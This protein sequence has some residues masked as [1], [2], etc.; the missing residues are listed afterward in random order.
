M[1]FGLLLLF[2]FDKDF[3]RTLQNQLDLIK[4]FDKVVDTIWVTE[5]HYSPI[6]LNSNPLMILNHLI[7][8]TDKDLGIATLL[9]SL[10]DPVYISEAISLLSNLSKRKIYIGA[11]KG[12]RSEVKNSHLNLKEE[13]ARERLLHTFDLVT[14]LAKNQTITL[15]DK[16]INI[17]PKFN[18]NVEFSL[19]SLNEKVIAYAAKNN[20][21]LMA[22]HKW[23]LEQINEMRSIYKKH[24]AKKQFPKIILS[25]IFAITQNKEKAVNTI[26]EN[27]SRNRALVSTFNK[28]HEPKELDEKI[29]EESLIGT[30]EQIG[31][32]LEYF[33]SIGVIHVILRPVKEE[34]E[35]EKL[36]QFNKFIN[37]KAEI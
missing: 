21:P 19:A 3:E 6:R 29:F 7:E 11:A 34:I 8:H 10:Y 13:S 35:Q 14:K 2:E 28:N 37:M 15:N 31:T 5:H 18:S 36:A 17:S 1:T 24:H 25:R 20:L 23:N 9:L 26:K 33:K 32:K 4:V 16:D 30:I 27:T 12:G 22:G